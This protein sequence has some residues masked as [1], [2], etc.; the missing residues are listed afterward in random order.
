MNIKDLFDQA[1]RDRLLRTALKKARTKKGGTFAFAFGMMGDGQSLLVVDWRGKFDSEKLLKELRKEGPRK[2]IVGQASVNG[3]LL[4]L[5][6]NQSKG[7][8]TSKDVREFL[9]DHAL[10][11]NKAIILGEMDPDAPPKARDPQAKRKGSAE[12]AQRG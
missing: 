11:V 1:K 10:S 8:V 4:E 3:R 6:V 12:P 5:S 2:A 9:T 7:T